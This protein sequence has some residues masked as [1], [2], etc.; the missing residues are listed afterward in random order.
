VLRFDHVVIAARTLGEGVDWVE[1]RLGVTVG[2]GGKHDV[3]G[4]HNRLL[5]LGP[6]RFLEVIAIDPDAP[7]PLQPR[8]FELDTPRMHERLA[9]GPALV[10]WVVRADDIEAALD[11]V[12]GA[13]PEVLALSRG[14]FRWKIGV[15]TDGHMGHDGVDPTIIQWFGQHPSDVLPDSG[16]R[17][18]SLVLHHAE[19]ASILHRLRYAGLST[20]DPVQPASE[21]AGLQVRIHTPRGVF[22]I[23]E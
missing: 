1:R 15:P 2:A 20:D 19:A 21:G 10:H 12:G 14:A 22:D 13:R 16:C 6:G 8:W 11:A 4:T 7:P 5:S 3:M 17:L 9:Q 18:Q 23:R